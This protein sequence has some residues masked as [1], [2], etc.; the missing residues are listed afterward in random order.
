MCEVENPG[1]LP[2]SRGFSLCQL[3]L[4]YPNIM[5]SLNS[6]AGVPRTFALQQN[7]PNPFNPTTTIRF[8]L[9]RAARV[10]LKIYDILGREVVTLI[11]GLQDAGFKSVG[12]DASALPSGVYVYGLVAREVEGKATFTAARKMILLK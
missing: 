1:Q 8:D 11:D 12:W 3:E 5:L 4:H 6:H 10:S 9:P 7:F 2:V